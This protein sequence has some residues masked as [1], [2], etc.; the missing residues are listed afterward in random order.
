MR[1]I[2]CFRF[3]FQNVITGNQL[4]PSSPPE[5]RNSLEDFHAIEVTNVPSPIPPSA[6]VPER[7]DI[8]LTSVLNTTSTSI[9]DSHS[10]DLSGPDHVQ[11]DLP[12]A[13]QLEGPLTYQDTVI[14]QTAHQFHTLRV[15][16][17]N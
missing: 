1:I 11:E 12:A 8:R 2:T 6:P 4:R 10:D 5:T 15:C 7:D 13:L 14:L 3:K 9:E 16:S 17:C